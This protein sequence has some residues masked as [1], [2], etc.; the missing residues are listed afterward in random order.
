MK[1]SNNFIPILENAGYSV[2]DLLPAYKGYDEE[3]I[4]DVLSDNAHMLDRPVLPYGL[5]GVHAY[6]SRYFNVHPAG[7]RA[8]GAVQPWP[9][10]NKKKNIFVFGGS[11]TVGVN[12][13]DSF[14]VPAYLEQ[15]L[16]LKGFDGYVYNWGSGN[17]ASRHEFLRLMSLIDQGIVPDS[18]IFLDGYNDCYYAF[19]NHKLVAILDA[20]Y[21]RE[22]RVRQDSIWKKVFM[23][24]DKAVCTAAQ[25]KDSPDDIMHDFAH[26]LDPESILDYARDYEGTL[27]AENTE[28]G[29]LAEKVGQRVLD[30]YSLSKRLIET[31]CKEY[32]ITQYFVWQPSSF[33]KTTTSQRVAEKT[34]KDFPCGALSYFAYHWLLNERFGCVQRLGDTI[35]LSE[36]GVGIP[37]VLYCDTCHYSSHFSKIIAEAIVP[38]LAV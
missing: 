35:N 13:E 12:V 14:T 36:V 32:G 11:T 18:V 38:H 22:K 25:K 6:T 24:W 19:E 34:Y 37:D 3:Y 27:L 7:F 4:S 21:Q 5:L 31:V 33:Y 10:D 2:T 30:R 26:S 1:Y 29:A 20:L 16:R 23:F 9:L 8:N 28:L 15:S 17:Y